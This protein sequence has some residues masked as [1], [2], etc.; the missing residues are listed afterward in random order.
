AT[1]RAVIQAQAKAAL[2]ALKAARTRR[3][4]GRTRPAL[5]A[6]RIVAANGTTPQGLLAQI[7]THQGVTVYDAVVLA[8]SNDSGQVGSQL[9]FYDLN[10]EL[11]GLFQTSQL[12]AVIVDPTN[13][14]NFSQSNSV[15][16]A[17]WTMGANIG[18]ASGSSN[19]SNVMI[20]KFCVGTLLDLVAKPSAWVDPADFSKP[21]PSIGVAVLS[22]ALQ[23]YI[24]AAIDNAKTNQLYTNFATFATN[25]DWQGIVVLGADLSVED[26]PEQL[27][28]LAA[29]IDF[30]TFRAHHFGVTVSPVT[31]GATLT[32]PGSS[33]MFGLIDYQLPAY[34]SN[35]ANGASPVQPLA[36]PGSGPY[37]F[38]VLQLQALF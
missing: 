22:Q 35:V 4:A 17:G 19:V 27:A 18:Q 3:S 29:G 1:R 37:G 20:L 5:A 31:Y 26:L 10:A 14:G 16:I 13:L 32:I 33:S 11:Q 38:T 25:P 15:D 30:S 24:A 34:A 12:F 8:Q 23:S 7:E 28:G 21:D 36:L 9:A 6:P 2:R